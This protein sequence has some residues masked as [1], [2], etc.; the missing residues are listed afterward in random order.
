MYVWEK[1]VFL[2]KLLGDIVNFDFDK[3][4]AVHG[5]SK[6]KIFAIKAGKLG[7]RSGQDTIKDELDKF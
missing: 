2:N 4:R 3:F 5:G 1:V 7:A 6:V